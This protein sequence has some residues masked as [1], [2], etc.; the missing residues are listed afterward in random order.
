MLIQPDGH[1][2]AELNIATALDDLMSPRLAEFMDAL[3]RVNALAERSEGFVWRLKDETGVDA[4]SIRAG[5]DPRLIV[6]LSVWETPEALKRFVWRTVHSRFVAR[7]EAWFE[8]PAEPTLVMWWT[9]KGAVPTVDE[10]MARLETLRAE[11]P[12][13]RA[14]GWA[15]IGGPD[16]SG[17]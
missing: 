16:P 15:E 14:F 10:A 5:E 1:H 4:T 2:L 13:D 12:T 8:T 7:R 6:N 9:P 17:C 11:G 3:A